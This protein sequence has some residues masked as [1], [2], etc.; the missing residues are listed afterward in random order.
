MQKLEATY[1]ARP[2]LWAKQR[3]RNPTVLTPEGV[4]KLTRDSKRRV[5]D[6]CA[7]QSYASFC[8]IE[9]KMVKISDR[10]IVADGDQ[11]A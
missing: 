4:A 11:P 1:R 2:C 5:V 7:C 10:A 8:A 9:C 6:Q 3:S